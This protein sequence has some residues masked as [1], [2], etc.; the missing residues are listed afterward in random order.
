MSDNQTHA[1][2]I[3]GTAASTIESLMPAILAGLSSGAAASNPYTATAA[4][5]A[6]VIIQLIKSNQAGAN[7]L[8]QII[9]AMMNGVTKDQATIEQIAGERGVS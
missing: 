6:P 7:D 4:A 2:I 3:A 5:I 1:Q 9:A 8:A